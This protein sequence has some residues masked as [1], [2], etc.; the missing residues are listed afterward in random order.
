[1]AYGQGLI[2]QSIAK[3]SVGNVNHNRVYRPIVVVD[4]EFLQENAALLTQRLF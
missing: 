4:G 1:M 3:W 2:H